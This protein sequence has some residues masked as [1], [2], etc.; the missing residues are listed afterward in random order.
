MYSL[1]SLRKYAIKTQYK[2]NK[3][4][5]DAIHK[6]IIIKGCFTLFYLV[7]LC[8]IGYGILIDAT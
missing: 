1:C 2:P 4:R 3:C 8:F 7:F 6:I 5:G